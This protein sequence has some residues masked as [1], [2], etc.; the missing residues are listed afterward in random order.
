[1]EPGASELEGRDRPI[2]ASRGDRAQRTQGAWKRL[3]FTYTRAVLKRC[4]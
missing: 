1:M 4:L 3:R 2:L